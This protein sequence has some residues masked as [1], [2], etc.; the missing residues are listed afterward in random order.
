MTGPAAASERGSADT[1]A[2]GIVDV[3]AH[4]TTDSYIAA[5]KR[6]GQREPDGMPEDYWPRW[7]VDQHLEF[8]EQAGIDRSIL[9]VSSPGVFLGDAHRAADLAREV[10]DAGAD[11]VTSA[12]D[13][14]G[15]LASLPLPAVDASLVEL[16]YAFDQLH[17]DGVVV[18]SNFEG[19]YLGDPALRP[20]LDELDRRSAAVLVH[21]TSCIG[22][23]SLALHRPRPMIEF[24]F[25]TARTVVDYVL[26]GAAERHPNIR[27]VVPH[28]GGVLP[29]LA[30]RVELFR[31]LSDAPVDRVSTADL[32][33]R[34]Y[35][36]LAGTPS[37]RQ[38][39]ALTS[40][41]PLEHVVYGSDYCWTRPEPVL[42]ALKLIDD[43]FPGVGVADWR[44]LTTDNARRLF[45]R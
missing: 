24:L 18:M 28:A 2:A 23:E 31:S 30:D 25:D 35:F 42:Q 8:M 9:S 36:D 3:H 34:M 13:R 26:S 22:H 21:P 33:A 44:R 12:P 40:V 20:V 39:A 4:F 1:S 11:V 14:F 38:M 16:G 27:I 43:V 15:L 41:V 17:V 32:L 7:T 6:A 29:L 10:N 5:A 37:T 19:T 45:T